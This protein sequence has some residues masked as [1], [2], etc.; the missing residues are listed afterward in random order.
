MDDYV[1]RF[2][3]IMLNQFRSC[4][5]SLHSGTRELG[6]E[7]F[8]VREW[9]IASLQCP[10]PIKTGI[11]WLIFSNLF[12]VMEFWCSCPIRGNGSRDA[13]FSLW[14]NLSNY[15][16]TQNINALLFAIFFQALVNS[17]K[18]HSVKTMFRVA[19]TQHRHNIND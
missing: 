6:L 18:F 12:H 13:I 11:T 19:Q 16:R 5:L 1:Q 3:N 2:G 7:S 10:C 14:E 8:T 9:Q 4:Q 15:N 17:A